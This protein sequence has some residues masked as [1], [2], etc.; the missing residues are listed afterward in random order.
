[1]IDDAHAAD[2]YIGDFWTVKLSRDDASQ[3]A[4]FESLASALSGH[5]RCDE[6]ARLCEPP[7]SLADHLWVQIVP[8]HVIMELEHEI[9]SILDEAAE[10][11]DLW[12]SWQVLKGHLGATQLFISP[13]EIV[14]RPILPPTSTHAPFANANQRIYMSA[15]LGRGGEL[16]RLSG[17]KAITPLPS[18]RG[19]NGH[20]VG[21]RF[22]IMPDVSLSEE[23][24]RNFIGK[25]IEQTEP[26]RALVLTV[27]IRSA[28]EIGRRVQDVLPRVSVYS[29]QEI[30]SSKEPFVTN[31]S[32]VAVIANRYDGIDFPQDECR[33]LIVNGKPSG[34]NL[35]ERYLCEVL[36]AQLLFAERTRTRMIQAFGRCTRS[37]T[38]YAIV[39]VTG[40]RLMNDL[41]RQEWRTG[42][43]PELQAELD[44]GSAQ[45]K[46]QSEEDLLEL[47]QLFLDQGDEWRNAEGQISSLKEAKEETLPESISGLSNSA[48]HE[49][50]YVTALWRGDYATAIGSAQ[51]VISALSGGTELKGF[52]GMWHYLAG[53]AE[54]HL[55]K[56]QGK[57][58][59]KAKQHFQ[60]ACSVA[61]MRI[62]SQQLQVESPDSTASSLDQAAIQSMEA[63]LC[64][65][66]LTT[67]G[68]FTGLEREIRDD[69]QKA[70]GVKFES[71]H[72]KL[73]T[74]LGFNS[75]NSDREGAPDPWWQIEDSLCFVFEDHI[76]KSDGDKLELDKARQ[77]KS[78]PNWI[79]ACVS[80]L[81]EDSDIIP[82]LLTNAD[83][84]SKDCQLQL[85]GVA[86]WP[87]AD[88]RE[89]AKRSLQKI[90]FLR[91]KLKSRGDL[92]WRSEA[93]SSLES[94]SATPSTLRAKLEGMKVHSK[95]S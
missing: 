50:D 70:R 15:T 23:E 92:V 19:W 32:A 78:H 1:M 53:C 61:G 6:Y 3:Q 7:T 81:R 40:E 56:E 13:S 16:Q 43:N 93:I 59:S 22:F 75:Q 14:F 47:A 11:T 85:Q 90:R 18:P 9:S 37:A 63:E 8:I 20:G 21:R 88:F 29:A 65:L 66:G 80:G 82:V 52:R 69:I 35:L 83:V 31:D 51:R 10:G 91:A 46:R 73:G 45:S 95:V 71:G 72:Q 2:Q 38:D 62:G 5:I 27:D 67:D 25:L 58:T 12:F 84:G 28:K 41:L 44:F 48:S 64:E 36:G 30:E 26:Q 60:T 87:L 89:W 24:T 49:I 33:L 68:K 57:D 76:K 77:A 94:I 39:C 86:V 55:A 4:L 42:V 17:R 54:F 74:L 79:K 34:M